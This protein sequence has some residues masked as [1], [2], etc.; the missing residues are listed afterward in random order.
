VPTTPSDSSPPSNS[1]DANR[2]SRRLFGRRAAF[3]AALSLSPTEL[4][5]ATHH[6]HREGQTTTDL[7]PEQS[8]EVE[9]KLANIIR[10]WGSRLSEDERKHLRRILAYNERM[11]A[12]IRSFPLENGDP[13]A[14]VLRVSFA[15]SAPRVNATHSAPAASEGKP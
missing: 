1:N 10:K 5:A 2:I 4:L 11:L 9:A 15:E 8:Q 7:T 13:P 6:S 12:S 14:S 3:A